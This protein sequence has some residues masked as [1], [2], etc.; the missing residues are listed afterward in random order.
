LR[1]R[2]LRRAIYHS[3]AGR[4]ELV[5][6]R[7]EQSSGLEE[8]FGGFVSADYRLSRRWFFGGR[9]DWSDR[10]REA[11]VRDRG[12]SVMTTFWPSEFT[13]IR[14]Q[15]RRTRFGDGSTANEFLFHTPFN[16]GAHG[17]HPF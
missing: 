7:R 9:Y 14:G 16:I 13:R 2:P 8:A 6:S 1:W 3:F 15:Y 11:D 10:A 12:F 5:W 4:A 17:E